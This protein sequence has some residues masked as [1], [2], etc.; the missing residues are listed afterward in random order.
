[1]IPPSTS[2]GIT[3]SWF[4]IIYPHQVE[5]HNPDSPF[6][7]LS[8]S[9]SPHV[10][11]VLRTNMRYVCEPWAVNGLVL[12]LANLHYRSNSCIRDVVD[13]LLASSFLFFFC[14]LLVMMHCNC[15]AFPYF[16]LVF[17][18]SKR[19]SCDPYY[20]PAELIL[21]WVH[22]HLTRVLRRRV[23]LLFW[24]ELV[25]W[26]WAAITHIHKHP[27]ADNTTPDDTTLSLNAELC[28]V[29][30]ITNTFYDNNMVSGKEKCNG[31]VKSNSLTVPLNYAPYDGKG[32][33][34]QPC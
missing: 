16:Y 19:T 12:K 11:V 15:T 13:A 31:S 24:L 28:I 3:V 4:S 25:W 23:T 2:A 14:V 17:R 26:K 29:P 10:I 8:L 30:A 34:F 7:S 22:T 5:K 1:M 32:W 20:F 27:C 18:V 6:N 9:C 21:L 33:H